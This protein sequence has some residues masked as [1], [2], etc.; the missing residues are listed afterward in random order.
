MLV[1][2]LTRISSL[3]NKLKDLGYV[4]SRCYLWLHILLVFFDIIFGAAEGYV[5][6]NAD[7][8]IPRIVFETND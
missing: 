2:A 3:V 6:F 1:I 4:K 8:R 5:A 7:P